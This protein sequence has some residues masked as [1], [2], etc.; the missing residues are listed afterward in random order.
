VNEGVELLKSHEARPGVMV[1]VRQGHLKP[2]L[3]GMLGTIK[4]SYGHPEYLA[5][6][7][8]LEDGRLELFWHHQLDKV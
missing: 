5:L 4:R 7:V 2:E 6:D 1:R 3:D 8:Q